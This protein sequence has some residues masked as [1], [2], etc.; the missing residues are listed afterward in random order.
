MTAHASK[1][2]TSL[3]AA[4]ILTSCTKGIPSLAIQAV[5]GKTAVTLG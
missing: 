4:S 1:A 5:P 2:W 3:T